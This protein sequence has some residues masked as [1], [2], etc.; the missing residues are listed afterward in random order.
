MQRYFTTFY[1]VEM[2]V[3]DGGRA[4]DHLHPE[5]ANLRFYSGT[6]PEA[7]RADGTVLRNTSFAATGPSSKAVRFRVGSSRMWGI[8]L[9]PAG[10][11]RFVPSPASHYGDA[12]LDGHGDPAFAPFRPLA[13][14]L[15][16]A[17]PDELGELE[18]IVAHF[19]SRLS[20][21]AADEERIA[22]I[23][24]ALV[25]P[26][27]ATVTELV[28][29]AGVSQRT[30]ERV[31]DRAF[32]FRPKVLLRRQRFMR[33]LAQ[34]MLDPSL[35]WIGAI[36]GHYHDQAQFVRDFRAFMGMTPRQYS[37][38]D[39]PIIAAIMQARARFALAA[40]QTLDAPADTGRT[41]PG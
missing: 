41:V 22:A 15:F 40:V 20:G 6:P 35:K 23:H 32:G 27:V 33:S 24:R 25:D 13:T 37:A 4:E 2:F 38:L 1:L 19:R 21:P 26:E 14:E 30:L 31:C 17:E 5:W 28:V 16:G 34:Y 11:A 12:V 29:R 18:R 8:G 10:W 3:G 9:L 7:A 39:K 36:D